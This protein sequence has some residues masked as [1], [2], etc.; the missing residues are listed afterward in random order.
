MRWPEGPASC[1]ARELVEECGLE[2][3]P[4]GFALVGA[5]PS[6][7]LALLD[8]ILAFERPLSSHEVARLRP[9]GFEITEIRWVDRTEL[10]NLSGLLQR[11]REFLESFLLLPENKGVSF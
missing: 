1:V 2:L 11:H 10:G 4:Q 8:L 6:D 9:D 3:P 5:L 7:R